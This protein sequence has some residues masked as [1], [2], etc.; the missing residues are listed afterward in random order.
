MDK[1]P[2]D[3]QDELIPRR[4]S[5]NGNFHAPKTR[6]LAGKVERFL[7]LLGGR[8]G[9]HNEGRMKEYNFVP[10]FISMTQIELLCGSAGAM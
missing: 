1:I 3:K 7:L 8:L 6:P 9:V 2:E 10:Q 5:G 4:P